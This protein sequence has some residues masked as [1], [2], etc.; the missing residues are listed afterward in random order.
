MD[1]SPP[2]DLLINEDLHLDGL[3]VTATLSSAGLIHWSGAK[4]GSLVIH[5]DVLGFSRE[6]SNIKLHAF[7]KQESNGW[8]GVSPGQRVRRDFCLSPG[9]EES[10]SN[11]CQCIRRCLDTLGRPKR[12]IVF[13]NPF[14]GKKSAQKIFQQE[15]KPLLILSGVAFTL[16]ETQFQRH[17]KDM[18]KSMD[19]SQF[20][21]ILCVSGDGILVEVVNGLLERTDWELAIKMPLG[22]IPAGTGNGMAKSLMDAAD[23]SCNAANATFAV[24]KGH[25][26]P[27]DVAT[28]VQGQARFFSVLMLTWGLIADIDIESEKYRWLGSIRL[29]FYTFLRVIRLRRY[30]GSVSFVPAPG[31]EEYGEPEKET[32]SLVGNTAVNTTD[33]SKWKTTGYLGPLASSESHEW[34]SIRG[35]FILVWLHNVPWA[36]EDAMPAPHAEFSDGYLDLMIVKEC[37][38]WSLLSLLLN[39]KDGGHVKSRY[40]QYLKVK[41]FRLAPGGR[42]SSSAQGGIIDLDGEVLARGQG[43]FGNNTTDPMLYGP[44][45]QVTI[46]KGLATVFSP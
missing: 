6:G 13:L 45:I 9:T 19:L 30:Y 35:N 43:A 8:C 18:A 4:S 21:G 31:Y 41:A 10:C 39:L 44:A 15:V 11:W 34:R 3:N 1:S 14:G 2:S 17:A 38:P 20:D 26:R 33:E 42:I 16:K 32:D 12:L 7:K 40:L 5:D 28:V 22:I 23:E 37:T 27:L 36:S 29:D 25:K 46:E 24:I